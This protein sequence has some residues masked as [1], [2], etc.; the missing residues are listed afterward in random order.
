MSK[1]ILVVDD[2]E[3]IQEVIKT[4]LED[5]AGWQVLLAGSGLEGLRIANSEA[6]DAILLDISMP[7][8]NG[9]EMLRK[10]QEND[11]TRKIPVFLLTARTVSAD[12]QQLEQVAGVIIKPFNI[13]KLVEQVSQSL[14]KRL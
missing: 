8:M 12:R 5:L 10:L 2:D 7:K 14:G 13:I 3:A 1:K 11:S 6:L 9:I 4:C